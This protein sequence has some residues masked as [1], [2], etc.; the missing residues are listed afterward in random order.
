MIIDFKK[1]K[2]K[3]KRKKQKKNLLNR[4][5]KKDVSKTLIFFV[6]FFLCLFF[7]SQ[8][9]C[10]I[11]NYF[12]IGFDNS[13]CNSIGIIDGAF[14]KDYGQ[15]LKE[16]NWS[17]RACNKLKNVKYEDVTKYLLMSDEIMEFLNFAINDDA[18]NH[19]TNLTKA[20]TKY[21]RLNNLYKEKIDFCFHGDKG[22][23]LVREVS[24]VS[25]YIANKMNELYKL[26]YR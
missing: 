6:V 8:Y 5:Y 3:I 26:A 22:K 20:N 24:R 9:K 17:T 7:F 14:K 1:Y 18:K 11:Y 10:K 21:K 19:I 13:V 12:G 15:E 16:T 25:N 4:A 23:E 2:K